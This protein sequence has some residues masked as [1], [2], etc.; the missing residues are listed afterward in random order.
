MSVNRQKQSSG[1]GGPIAFTVI[2]IVAAGAMIFFGTGG[3]LPAEIRDAKGKLDSTEAALSSTQENAE[4][5]EEHRKS[6]QRPLPLTAAPKPTP[7]NIPARAFT[8]LYPIEARLIRAGGNGTADEPVP[9]P[10]EPVKPTIEKI[11][12][13]IAPSEISVAS[14]SGAPVIHVFWK[15]GTPAETQKIVAEQG[16]LVWRAAVEGEK[17]GPWQL[18]TNEL[19][20]KNEFADLTANAGVTYR[21]AVGAAVD[22]RNIPGGTAVERATVAGKIKRYTIAGR[23]EAKDP[24]VLSN[25]DTVTWA[26]V[27]VA[28]NRDTRSDELTAVLSRWSG[29]KNFTGTETTWFQLSL[30]VSGIGMNQA[31]GGMYKPAQLNS[32]DL[33]NGQKGILTVYSFDG[34]KLTE[35]TD[36]QTKR[37][38]VPT[39]GIDFSAG[40]Q[41]Q[42]NA[43]IPEGNQDPKKVGAVS[44]VPEH[45]YTPRPRPVAPPA[46]TETPG[47]EPGTAPAPGETP[48]GGTTPPPSETPPADE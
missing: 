17:T 8:P 22:E 4:T 43:K 11:D 36:V 9:P 28:V 13:L 27:K 12:A 34:E 47:A 33:G 32:G 25:V 42:G 6:L 44:D 23:V 1:T 24:A 40:V 48:A 45:P 5:I 7:S 41:F 18:L 26:K 29:I 30:E 14:R 19:V 37:R 39:E 20:T 38:A 15:V 31:I 2:G 3:D 10:E 21:Y 35:V 16:Y 46:P